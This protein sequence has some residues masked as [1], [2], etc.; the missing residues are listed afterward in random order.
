MLSGGTNTGV[1]QLAGEIRNIVAFANSFKRRDIDC[2]F[3]GVDIENNVALSVFFERG[4]IEKI[5]ALTD[6]LKVRRSGMVSSWSTRA[7]P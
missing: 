5:E 3:G 6:P 7:S 2:S 1:M 4:V